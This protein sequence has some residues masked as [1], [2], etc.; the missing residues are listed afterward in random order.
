MQPHQSDQPK[1]HH[2]ERLQFRH[3]RENH[4][5]DLK[6]IVCIQGEGGQPRI[7]DGKR[8]QTGDPV[9]R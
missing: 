2:R 5:V 4:I 8:R 7:S 9:V 6:S 1:Q 3:G